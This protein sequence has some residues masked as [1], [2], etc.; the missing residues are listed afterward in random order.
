[1]EKSRYLNHIK[2]DEIKIKMKNLIDKI[3]KTELNYIPTNTD[4][5]NPKEI[6]YAKS[7]LNRF[8][9]DY[10]IKG[11]FEEAERNIIYIY[12]NNYNDKIKCLEI[13][14]NDNLD[15]RD[16][17]GALMGLKIKRKK[18]GDIVVKDKKA[19]IFVLEELADFIKLNL[20]DV[21][22]SKVSV[23]YTDNYIHEE[24]SYKMDT[25]IIPSSRLDVFVARI[26]NKSRSDTKKYIKQNMIK[27]NYEEVDDLSYELNEGDLIS[28]RGY[29]R[30]IF[31]KITGK[32]RKNNLK[33]KIKK[34]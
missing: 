34:T 32:T 29:G 23:S 4:F 31:D 20:K 14:S 17:L 28:I 13:K 15:H 24:K 1:M 25:I 2:D 10:D 19:Y 5:L 27:V 16:Y 30:I 7:I 9:V 18:I 21:G 3:R 12:L 26:I 6:Y 11:G 8:E 22:N 33:V